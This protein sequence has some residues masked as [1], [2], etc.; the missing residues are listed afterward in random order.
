MSQNLVTCP[1]FHDLILKIS[2]IIGISTPQNQIIGDLKI[3][4]FG[5]FWQFPV[6]IDLAVKS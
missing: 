3:I 6:F 1:S 2:F 4:N 5:T